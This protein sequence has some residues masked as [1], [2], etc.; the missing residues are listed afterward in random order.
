MEFLSNKETFTL[1]DFKQRTTDSLLK[2]NKGLRAKF[3]GGNEE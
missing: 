2:M 3:A 1:A